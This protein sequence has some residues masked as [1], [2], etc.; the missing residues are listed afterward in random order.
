MAIYIIS[1][2]SGLYLGFKGINTL[3]KLV[4]DSNLMQNGICLK[5]TVYNK[6][7][8]DDPTSFKLVSLLSLNVKAEKVVGIYFYVLH[9]NAL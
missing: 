5:F 3:T 7:Y 9:W 4:Q 2:D 1:S 6:N 8:E